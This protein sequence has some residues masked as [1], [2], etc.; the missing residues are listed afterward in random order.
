M[1]YLNLPVEK[2]MFSKS[3]GMVPQYF[4]PQYIFTEFGTKEYIESIGM[5]VRKILEHHIAMPKTAK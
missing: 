5:Q 4:S 2:I 3:W 1:S